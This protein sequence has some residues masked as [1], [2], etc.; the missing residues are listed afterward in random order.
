MTAKENIK[1]YTLSPKRYNL[2]STN[3]GNKISFSIAVPRKMILHQVNALEEKL[4]IFADPLE[5]SPPALGQPN[6]K[7]IID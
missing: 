3:N 4:F 6:V 7:N 2:K 1:K 5:D